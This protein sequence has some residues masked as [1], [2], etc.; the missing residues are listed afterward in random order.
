MSNNTKNRIWE[1][2][3][4]STLGAFSQFIPDICLPILSYICLILTVSGC[5]KVSGGEGGRKEALVEERLEERVEELL[6]KLV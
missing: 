5:V 3:F 1:L 4:Q 6:E 2:F